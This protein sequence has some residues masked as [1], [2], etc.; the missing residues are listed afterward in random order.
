LLL[1]ACAALIV[2]QL[3]HTAGC[4]HFTCANCCPNHLLVPLCPV[5]VSL[6]C[7]TRCQVCC[8][9]CCAEGAG[10]EVLSDQ[11]A[12]SLAPCRSLPPLLSSAA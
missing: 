2:V 10:L 9:G 4:G 8:A 1:C 5:L 6:Q 3:T 7:V 12:S 11:P